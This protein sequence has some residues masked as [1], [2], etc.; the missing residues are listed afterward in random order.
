MC[1][2]FNLEGYYFLILCIANC[3]DRS[4]KALFQLVH[5]KACGQ[6]N[7]TKIIKFVLNQL[8]QTV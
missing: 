1:I 2:T 4:I 5:I 3:V 6:R 7:L 8:N